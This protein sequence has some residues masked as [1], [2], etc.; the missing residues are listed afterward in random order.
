MVSILFLTKFQFLTSEASLFGA[1]LGNFGTSLE[2]VESVSN[3]TQNSS[4]A[5]NGS[6][7]YEDPLLGFKF[8]YP[9]QWKQILENNYQNTG[10]VFELYKLV[11]P[12]SYL[13]GLYLYIAED[14]H[15]YTANSMYP[16]RFI[17]GRFVTM[18]NCRI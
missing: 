13:N 1:S 5:S 11:N 18:E 14:M 17:E 2:P 16:V 12:S 3:E 10:V 4:I 7:T 9:T 15:I 6:L 8:Q